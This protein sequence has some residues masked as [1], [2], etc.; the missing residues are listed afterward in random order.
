[1]E[2][3]VSLL[4]KF[5]EQTGALTFIRVPDAKDFTEEVFSIVSLF[6]LNTSYPTKAT[7][8]N[9]INNTITIFCFFIE[10]PP[11]HIND[12][13]LTCFFQVYN[14]IFTIINVVLQL[15]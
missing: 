15:M 8:I 10:I 2:E 1:M 12:I 13:I 3:Y 11:Y 14:Y 6:I 4:R 5:R 9:S 7:S